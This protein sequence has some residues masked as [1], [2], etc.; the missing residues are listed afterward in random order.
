MSREIDDSE[1]W[2]S[3]V[4]RF[5]AGGMRREELL[6]LAQTSA[7]LQALGAPSLPV[8]MTQNTAKKVLQDKHGLSVDVVKS[9]P[10][11][12]EQPVAVFDS[13]TQ[14][15]ALVILTESQHN[16]KPVIA[17]IHLDVQRGSVQV[18][19]IAS[20]YG[21]DNAREWL[22]TQLRQNTRYYDKKKLLALIRPAGLQLPGKP[23]NTRSN[24]E[25][26]TDEHL[27]NILSQKS[28]KGQRPE[29]PAQPFAEPLRQSVRAYL[30]AE[31]D[32]QASFRA[33]RE[34]VAE[35][36]ASTQKAKEEA[37]EHFLNE[38]ERFI[39]TNG[40]EAFRT[41]M[42]DVAGPKAPTLT[43]EV[44]RSRGQNL[45]KG[46]ELSLPTTSDPAKPEGGE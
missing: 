36:M 40:V 39:N 42:N 37:R 35:R 24:V 7:V 6:V 5:L 11:H 41:Q 2:S 12:L 44:L 16:G 31:E 13:V 22:L 1:G 25:V 45:D 46:L 15:D 8:V 38:A 27:V 32:Y 9:L 10:K 20:V 17:A 28:S 18:N 29:L 23:S 19:N 34:K 30:A 43:N 33:P 14:P 26:L 3:D 21:K 4:D